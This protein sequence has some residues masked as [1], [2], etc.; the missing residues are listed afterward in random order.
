MI[1]LFSPQLIPM[2]DTEFSR[3][4]HCETWHRAQAGLEKDNPGNVP[5]IVLAEV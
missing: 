2:S 4:R 3:K 5:G 1:A